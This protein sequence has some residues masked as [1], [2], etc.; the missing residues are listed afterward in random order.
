[1]F[2]AANRGYKRL[3]RARVALFVW[4]AYQLRR[5]PGETSVRRPVLQFDNTEGKRRQFLQDG[6]DR[7]RV[8]EEKRNG[9]FVS[10]DETSKELAEESRLQRKNLSILGLPKRK[11]CLSATKRAVGKYAK[12]PFCKRKREFLISPES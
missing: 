3:Q 10:A 7:A 5:F 9:R 1:M 4:S 11:E 12:P 6:E 2:V 8:R